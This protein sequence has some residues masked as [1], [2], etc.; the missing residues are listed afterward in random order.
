MRRDE[1]A[2]RGRRE[3]VARLQ[4]EFEAEQRRIEHGRRIYEKYR[5]ERLREEEIREHARICE[6][7][8]AETRRSQQPDNRDCSK[9]GAACGEC[10]RSLTRRN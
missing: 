9:I 1:E 4:R 2:N 5:S 7:V 8:E 3:E 6:A 10:F